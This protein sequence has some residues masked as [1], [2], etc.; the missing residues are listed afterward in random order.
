MSLR[1]KN[2]SEKSKGTFRLGLNGK[3]VVGIFVPLVAILCVLA[4][5]LTIQVSNVISNVKDDN[6]ENQIVAASVQVNEYFEKFFTIEN[7]IKEQSI[8]KQMLLES[9][10]GSEDFSFTDSTVYSDILTSLKYYKSTLGNAVQNMW[11]AGIKNN[12]V[13]LAEGSVTEGNFSVTDRE[14][15]KLIQ[16]KPGRGVLTAAYRDVVAGKMIVTVASPYYN[17]SNKLV[18]VIGID[19][20]L[21]ELT[22]FLNK[23]TIG[24]TGYVTIYD[25]AQNIIYHP[26]SELIMTNLSQIEYSDNI[27]TAL[28]NQ[29]T[30]DFLKYQCDKNTY[31]GS[32]IYLNTINWAVIG[33][34]P[35]KEYLKDSI[36]IISTTELGFIICTVILVLICISRAK[37]IVRP[38]Q[39]LNSAASEFAKGNLDIPI[40]KT[41]DDEI[42]DLTDVFINTQKGLKDIIWD[43][44]YV[45]DALSNKNL[46]VT[47]SAHYQGDFVQI[48]EDLNT[49]TLSM[50]S[51]MSIINDTAAQV[52]VG[53]NQI[54][55]TSQLLAE[56]A[57]EQASAV[58]ELASTINEVSEQMQQMAKDASFASEKAN[59]VGQDVQ[60]SSE[61]MKLMMQ[62]MGRIDQSSNEIQKIIK[63]IEDIAFQTNILALNAA[64][65]AA[66]AGAAGKGFAVV[67]DEVRNLA[68][69]SAEASKTTETLISNSLS[70]VKDGLLLA[71]EATESLIL[72]A[73]DVQTVTQVVNDV[74][75]DLQIHSKSM[76]D[77][78]YGIDQISSVVK[79]NSAT[80]EESAASSEELSA[81]ANSLKQ[82]MVEFKLRN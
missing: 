67:A 68:G 53:A 62:A 54:A 34:M 52:D 16:D 50:N 79:T 78:T 73:A 48:K 26:N 57:T 6:I 25:S 4:I 5:V 19:I 49:I 40:H 51:V 80:S 10:Q 72:A 55:S 74:S 66:R 61:K 29:Q 77:L 82:M 63:A 37:T 9:E 69:K 21:D 33:C 14:W 13:L 60:N 8:I 47:T 39:I 31:Y 42:G 22:A 35:Q 20:E 1:Q 70:A 59:E 46:Q 75:N 32:T 11:I 17:S 56:G 44:G 71:R 45:L 24:E 64:V 38:L 15:Y 41:T 27:K 58:E 65:E 76:Q 18:G 36:Y 43:I 2:V 28:K 3:L 81:Q 23:I 12:Q 7:I 30:S